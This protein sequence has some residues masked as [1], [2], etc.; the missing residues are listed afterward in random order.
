MRDLH[1]FGERTKSRAVRTPMG[2]LCFVTMSRG[3]PVE[4]MVVV[5]SST[6]R[7]N[8]MDCTGLDMMLRASTSS[9]LSP[10]ATTLWTMSAGVM[11]PMLLSVSLINRQ[12]T[13]SLCMSRA[14]S[15]TVTSPGICM[16]PGVIMWITARD[17]SCPA[18]SRELSLARVIVRGALPPAAG[19]GRVALR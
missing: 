9:G 6:G 4:T 11:M 3:T 16:T 5:A 2:W 17:E 1:R 18:A 14:A 19:S 13:R 7:S 12:G 10:C 15:L 8:S